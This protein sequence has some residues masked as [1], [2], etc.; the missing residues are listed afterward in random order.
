[1]ANGLARQKVE[2][3]MDDIRMTRN[4]LKLNLGLVVMTLPLLACT[5]STSLDLQSRS[6]AAQGQP[7]T[8]DMNAFPLNKTVCDPWSGQTPS[9]SENGVRARLAHRSSG[10]PDW[11]RSEDYLRQGTASGRTLFF[12]DLNV[13]T[14]LFDQ[15]FA[16][17]TSAVVT[18][19][20]GE[21]LIEYFGL[22]FSTQLRLGTDDP[23]GDYELAILSDDGST[24]RISEAR[25]TIGP[26]DASGEVLIDNEGAH[27][28]RLGCAKRAVSLQQGQ[29]LDLDL[30]YYQGPRMHIAMILLWRPTNASVTPEP[31][32]GASGN[33]FFFDPDRDSSPQKNYRSLLSRGWRPVPAKNLFLPGQ[34]VFNPCVTGENLEITDFALVEASSFQIDIQWRTNRAATSQALV[35]RVLTGEEFLTDS[36]QLLRTTHVLRIEGL[37]SDETYEI[38]PVSVAE[39]GAKVIGEKL[40]VKTP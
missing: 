26:A 1:M 22:Q 34:S 3:V 38:Q 11:N 31:L 4:V 5:P 27:P 18:N 36:D 7:S 19:D 28:T 25:G 24:L 12:S 10:Q 39:D 40:T 16:T 33:D 17:Q 9:T 35:K 23:A 14:R 2:I 21:K 8:R 30:S 13:P 32:C 20:A 15:G 37:E 29:G 6:L